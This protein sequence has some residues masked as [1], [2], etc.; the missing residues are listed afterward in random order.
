MIQNPYQE[1]LAERS[2]TIE[3]AG[4]GEYWE[5]RW[6]IDPLTN[7][8]AKWLPITAYVSEGDIRVLGGPVPRDMEELNER[9]KAVQFIKNRFEKEEY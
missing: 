6:Y 8:L 4:D 1:A 7:G 2:L 5:F 3:A 9:E